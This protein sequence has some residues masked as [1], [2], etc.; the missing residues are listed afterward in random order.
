MEGVGGGGGG[1]LMAA[2]GWSSHSKTKLVNSSKVVL[3]LQLCHI[4]F[5][6]FLHERVITTVMMY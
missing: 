4:S 3:F 1:R 5:L 2:T 6:L